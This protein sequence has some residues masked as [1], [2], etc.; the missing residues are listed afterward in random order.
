VKA[1]T[2]SVKTWVLYTIAVITVIWLTTAV[3]TAAAQSPTPDPGMVWIPGGTFTMGS[4]AGEPG[5]ENDETQHQVTLGGFYLGRY[6]VTQAQ[7]LAVMGTNP[8]RFQTPV[9]PETS[10]ASRPVEMVRWYDAIVFCNRLSMG[11]GLNPAYRIGGSTDPAAWGAVPTSSNA[12]WNA[13]EIVAGSNGYRLPTEAQWEYA[14]RA[15]STAAFNW[16]T[17]TINSTQANYNAV[18]IDASNTARGTNPNRTT[19]VGTYAPNAWGLYDMHGNVYE[20]CWDRSGS[21][22]S[23]SQTEPTGA[24]SG[25]VR[26]RRGGSWANSGQ[27]L[28]SA[29]RNNSNP[30]Q[31]GDNIIT[32]FRL[33]RP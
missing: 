29:S 19:A 7:Y 1:S 3:R 21:Y 12:A 20:W 22:A 10:T 13:V 4:P 31:I 32:G 18:A 28:R 2:K 8:S 15:G 24:A 5:R 33:A 6:P 25:N 23:G 27:S 30:Y 26:M 9:S 17:N 14:C 16:G 11:E